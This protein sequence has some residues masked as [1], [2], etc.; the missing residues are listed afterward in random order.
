MSHDIKIL[1]IKD[2][3]EGLRI[4]YQ[5]G[6]DVF[7][8]DSSEMPS[9][10]FVEALDAL[11]ADVISICDLPKKYGETMRVTGVALS[12]RD[13]EEGESVKAVIKAVKDL[14]SGPPLCLNTPSRFLDAVEEGSSMLPGETVKRIRDLCSQAV[15]YI[16]GNRALRQM[17]TQGELHFDDDP[18]IEAEVAHG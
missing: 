6:G 17:V 18:V 12:R 5:M 8:L 15:L 2:K 16:K 4:A 7:T 10:M 3:P 14:P 1:S 9:D 11:K 13:G